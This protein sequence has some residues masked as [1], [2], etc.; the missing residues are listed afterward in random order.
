M[1]LLK[2]VVSWN[3]FYTLQS[4]YFPVIMSLFQIV[5]SSVKFYDYFLEKWQYNPELEIRREGTIRFLLERRGGIIITAINNLKGLEPD[6]K[7]PYMWKILLFFK[8]VNS[9]VFLLQTWALKLRNNYYNKIKTIDIKFIL[10][11]AKLVRAWELGLVIFA[12]IVTWNYAYS[13]FKGCKKFCCY[14]VLGY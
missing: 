4:L 2:R 12:W 13:P 14:K 3:Y 9:C 8:S 10:D 6:F 7:W 5:K 11:L 1:L